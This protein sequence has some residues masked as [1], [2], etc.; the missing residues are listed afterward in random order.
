MLG[1][2]AGGRWAEHWRDAPL[3]SVGA[4]SQNPQPVIRGKLSSH[5]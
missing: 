1:T 4:R 2:L 3:V 5:T